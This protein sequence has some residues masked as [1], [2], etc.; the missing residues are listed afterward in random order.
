MMHVHRLL[1]VH[2][3]DGEESTGPLEDSVRTVAEQCEGGLAAVPSDQ[4][5]VRGTQG[6]WY[7]F[8]GSLLSGCVMAGLWPA[9]RVAG[10]PKSVQ[11]S[12]GQHSGYHVWAFRR[13]HQPST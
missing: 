10:D 3:L 4:H 2:H 1:A 8:R 6:G 7:L 5:A 13:Q 12:Q 9:C 11:L